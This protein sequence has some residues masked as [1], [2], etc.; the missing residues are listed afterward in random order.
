M[1]HTL[2]ALLLLAGCTS[3]LD[4][5]EECERD[6]AC[7]SL[8][9]DLVCVS[10]RCVAPTVL[11]AGQPRDRGVN[12]DQDAQVR[13]LDGLLGQ[14]CHLLGT[15]ASD[16]RLIGAFLPADGT[17]AEAG[18]SHAAG[19]INSASGLVGQPVG[20]LACPTPLDPDEAVARAQILAEVTTEPVLIGADSATIN[21]RLYRDVALAYGLVLLTPGAA[22]PSRAAVEDDGLLWHIRGDARDEALALTRM[23]LET[24]P[25]SVAILHRAD[26]WGVDLLG[27]TQAVLC[28]DGLCPDGATR[29]LPFTPFGTDLLD[30]A[31]EAVEADVIVALGRPEDALPLFAALADVGAPRVFALGGPRDASRLAH[32]FSLDAEGRTRLP[33]WRADARSALLCGSATVGPNRRGPGWD[34]WSGDFETVWPDVSAEA[35]AP[36]VDAVFALAYAI[37]AAELTGGELTGTQV[38]AGFERLNDG[39]RIRVGRMDWSAGIAGLAEGDINLE[40]ASGALVFDPATG[41]AQGG[42]DATWYDGTP[43]GIRP[44]GEVLDVDGRYASPVPQP[45]CG[46]E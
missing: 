25:A 2:L 11:D 44:A 23:V 17:A 28:A 37:A 4:F 36:Y 1:R 41:V 13:D 30:A 20:V 22:E 10:G 18:L 46:E 9:A 32:L 19:D 16:A 3:T 6:E 21:T 35:A 7:A 40:G 8:G 33:A 5:S 43:E 39:P 24:E 15:T 29:A 34:A 38:A 31:A 27:Q 14:G 12:P 45:A 26:P 42:V